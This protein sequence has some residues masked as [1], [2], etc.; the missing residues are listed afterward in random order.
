[1]SNPYSSEGY[2][3]N[4]PGDKRVT[5]GFE[6]TGDYGPWQINSRTMEDFMRRYPKTVKK[7]G[8]TSVEDLKDDI[9]S[10]KLAKL[11]QGEQGWTNKGG[12]GWKGWVD[13]GITWKK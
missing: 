5:P 10:T 7:M 3:Y 1:M 13:K 4:T 8:I 2:N 11:I 6:G 12:G 9:K